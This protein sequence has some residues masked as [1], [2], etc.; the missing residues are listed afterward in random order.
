MMTFMS[1]M[2][3]NTSLFF[4]Y[5]ICHLTLFLHLEFCREWEWVRIQR[6]I[7]IMKQVVFFNTLDDKS[8]SNRVFFFLLS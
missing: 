3:D 1:Q 8:F 5:N 7:Y 2:Q 6:D 4:F